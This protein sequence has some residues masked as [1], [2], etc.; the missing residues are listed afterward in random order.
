MDVRS[1]LAQ[2][3]IPITLVEEQFR[4]LDASPKELRQYVDNEYR[5]P[6]Y[7]IHN[8]IHSMYSPKMSYYQ[9][10][11]LN[12]LL[13]SFRHNCVRSIALRRKLVSALYGL[14]YKP[15]KNEIRFG[16]KG[17][18]DM[19]RK[20]AIRQIVHQIE[21]YGSVYSVATRYV[22][23]SKEVYSWINSFE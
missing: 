17:Q 6:F 4:C 18:F 21:E 5:V 22:T 19:T 15:R 2:A 23:S 20:E 9:N 3:L 10:N 13:D 8:Q 14:E 1:E 7:R 12:V 16:L 11:R